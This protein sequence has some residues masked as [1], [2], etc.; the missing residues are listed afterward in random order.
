L[1]ICALTP[2]YKR[3]LFVDALV[4]KIIEPDGFS[5]LQNHRF[6]ECAFFF[7]GDGSNFS[8]ADGHAEHWHWLDPLT[9]SFDPNSVKVQL[10]LLMFD[11][12]DKGAGEV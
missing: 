6:C 2:I 4:F 11:I 10:Q 8:F 1:S 12:D 3:I 5:I 7:H 9:A